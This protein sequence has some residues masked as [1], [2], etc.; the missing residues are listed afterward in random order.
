MF[1]ALQTW[2]AGIAVVVDSALLFV[3]L[4]RRN[5][6]FARV[7][8]VNL[9]VG[10]WLL[11]AGAFLML[12]VGPLPGFGAWFRSACLL[13]VATGMLLMPSAML[14]GA[15][16][17]SQTGIDLRKRSN[18]AYAALYLPVAAV[19]LLLAVCPSSPEPTLLGTCG[20]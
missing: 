3:L 7:P 15:I 18:P 13:A 20:G 12:T 1:E 9:L 19:G 6:P 8:I 5:R 10:A 14:H 17:Y 4:E 11:H 16:R 2:G